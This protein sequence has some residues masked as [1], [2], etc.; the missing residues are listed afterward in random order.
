[1]CKQMAMLGSAI[2][3]DAETEEE[4][5]RIMPPTMPP[6]IAATLS[7]LE[8]VPIG[9]ETEEWDGAVKQD[10]AVSLFDVEE[11]EAAVHKVLPLSLTRNW[12]LKEE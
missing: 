5:R 9:R 4:D 11:D 7:Q 10:V 6:V 1:M 2:K 3:E 12:L 8:V